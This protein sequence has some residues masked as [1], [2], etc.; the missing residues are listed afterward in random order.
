MSRIKAAVCGTGTIGAGI[1]TLL[2]GNGVETTV[3]GHSESGIQRCRETVAQNLAELEQASKLTAKQR[4]K[5]LSLLTVTQNYND[6]SGSSFV[7]EAVAEDIAVK[8]SVYQK[9]E[10]VCS[11]ETI[12]ASTTSALP[13]HVLCQ[14]MRHPARMLVAH[15]FQPAHLLPLF[16]LVGSPKTD[17]ASFAS[18]K[19]FLETAL[20]RQVVCLNREIEGFIVNRIAQAMFRE[21]LYLLENGVAS[22][23]EL[24]KA[25]HYA[26]GMRY[27]SIGLLEYFDDVGFPLERDI[28]KTIYPT[29]CDETDIQKIVLDGLESGRTGMK[30]GTGL[31]SWTEDNIRE[32]NARKEA[33][34]LNIF[35]WNVPTE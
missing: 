2:A 25:I 30:A 33:P 9:V 20:N 1:A 10:A 12:L 26:V 35:N 34:Y 29:L 22:A 23:A 21:C 32:F 17:A 6:L 7:F 16:E 4:E 28:A 15:P 27:A 31:Y 11:E 3:V 14:G 13:P 24:D 19:T 5:I 8:R 18:M